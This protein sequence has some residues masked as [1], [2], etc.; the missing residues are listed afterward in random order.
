MPA[1]G[2]YSLRHGVAGVEAAYDLALR[3][4]LGSAWADLWAEF[5]HRHPVGRDVQLTLE[6]DL[7]AAANAALAGRA[8]AAV[9]LD[10][11]TGDI[12]AL[13][14]QPTY[15]PNQLDERFN[16]YQNDEGAPLLNRA[17]QALYQPGAA[18]FPFLLA[19]GL[20]FDILSPSTPITDGRSASNGPVWGDCAQ[21][22]AKGE[23]MPTEINLS[24]AMAYG[25]PAPFVDLVAA[26]GPTKLIAGLSRLGLFELA[27]L[28]LELATTAVPDFAN[29][30][31]D[32]EAVGQGQ[33][34][35]SPL[36]MA[37]AVA[38]IAAEGV[39][40]PLRLVSQVQSETGDWQVQVSPALPAELGLSP[41]AAEG[42][43]TALAAAVQT[44]STQAALI[45]GQQA[46]GY[47]AT[48]LTGPGESRN[49]WFL[50]YL[51]GPSSRY[52]VVVLLEDTDRSDTAARSARVI[53]QAL[54]D[55]QSG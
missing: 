26:L 49:A 13:A 47:A 51:H 34:T 15:D 9:V 39:L 14:S 25:C 52:V 45:Q 54:V 42:T 48:A 24:E 27:D 2:Y 43:G 21:A 3:G 16:D 40:P 31:L 20:E 50:G 18:I 4:G 30:G 12:L 5:T 55:W 11:R 6:A 37:W 33:L 44:G 7:Q 41:A 17:T 29:G 10:A 46:V 23:A 36:H 28:P 35:M 32:A 53:F 19:A 22:P 38:A 1:I 8:G